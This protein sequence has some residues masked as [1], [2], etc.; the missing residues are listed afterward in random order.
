MQHISSQGKVNIIYALVG[1]IV[2]LF[3]LLLPNNILVNNNV[4]PVHNFV[5][6]ENWIDD[7]GQVRI[8]DSNVKLPPRD[9]VTITG[10]VTRQIPAGQRLLMYIYQ[11]DS[12]VFVNGQ[13]IAN[14]TD[15]TFTRWETSR[16]PELTPQ[17]RITI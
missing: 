3:L 17:D 14:V 11:V 10:H 9:K 16:L 2:L 12:K 5:F 4:Q 6:A 1:I 7:N 15:S 13:E 8:L